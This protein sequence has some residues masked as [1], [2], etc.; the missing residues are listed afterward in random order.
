EASQNFSYQVS[1]HRIRF[2]DRYCSFHAHYLP[3]ASCIVRPMVAGEDAMRIPAAFIASI[4]SFA[5]PLPP[6][7]IAPAWPMRFPGGAVCPAINP[8]T[9]FFML[10]WIH[11]A[12]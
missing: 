5:V 6:E 8:A 10:A 2:H 11:A 7:M 12:A 9:G 4:F 1:R 3:N